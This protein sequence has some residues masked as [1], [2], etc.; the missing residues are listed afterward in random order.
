MAASK[1]KK[2]P[3]DKKGKKNTKRK[4]RKSK[5]PPSK[6][7]GKRKGKP[8][9]RASNEESEKPKVVTP[10]R[11][12]RSEWRW[13][14]RQKGGKNKR[15]N[16]QDWY[17][18]LISQQEAE[19]YLKGSPEGTFLVRSLIDREEE[20]VMLSVICSVKE[21]EAPKY[22]H[23]K[24]S[25]KGAN[26]QLE[27]ETGTKTGPSHRSIIELLDYY[28]NQFVGMKLFTLK[29]P[30]KRPDWFLKSHKIM[31]CGDNS[32]LGS[33][34]FSKV[35]I[36][37]FRRRLVAIKIL[38]S[39]GNRFQLDREN[40]MKEAT[41]THKMEH[42][43]IT[44]TIGIS[45]D[46]LPPMLVMELMGPSLLSHLEKYGKYTTIGEKLHYCL[47]MAYGLNYMTEKGIVHR[48]I[49]ARNAM[50]SRY[51]IL[52]LA[53]FGLSDFA[54]NLTAVNT[55][56]ATLPMK[57]FPPESLTTPAV[58]NEKTDVWMF[59]VT[60]NEI[61]GNGKRPLPQFDSLPRGQNVGQIIAK[62]KDGDILHVF[63][64]FVPNEIQS[65]MKRLW[66]RN[67][68]ERPCFKEIVTSLELWIKVQYPAPPL[69]RQTVNMIPECTP[70][71]RAEYEILYNN[72]CDWLPA[73]RKVKVKKEKK[74]T[75]KHSV[76]GSKKNARGTLKAMKKKLRQKRKRE[77]MRIKLRWW[78]ERR[79]NEKQRIKT[80]IDYERTCQKKRPKLTI[81]YKKTRDGHVKLVDLYEK[82]MIV[83]WRKRRPNRQTRFRLRRH[84]LINKKSKHPASR[85]RKSMIGRKKKEERK[86]VEVPKMPK[87][88]KLVVKIGQKKV[89]GGKYKM[90][91]TLKRGA[92]ANR[93]QMDPKAE[94]RMRKIRKKKRHLMRKLIARKL[95]KKR[96]ALRRQRR[97]QTLRRRHRRHR[98]VLRKKA[99]GVD[100]RERMRN[101][102]KRRRE[103]ARMKNRLKRDRRIGKV[104]RDW[105]KLRHILSE[106]QLS[107]A[108][109]KHL[110]R[111]EKQLKKNPN[112]AG[113]PKIR[114]PQSG[115]KK[116][117]VR[118]EL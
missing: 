58:F 8:T 96:R 74:K 30:L 91:P 24:I 43:H 46:T 3:E 97:R 22:D 118:S 104:L 84:R 47:Q 62:Y 103:K 56:R 48:D 49:S 72:N 52:K 2:R 63:P 27:L 36:G 117:K 100:L 7:N 61:F 114:T 10:K 60:C 40:L 80:L 102:K 55:A 92:S 23:L 86:R 37:A 19:A 89:A 99:L 53:D 59:G 18:G 45:I 33:G 81:G 107:R 64:N 41:I 25:I 39:D 68:S 106:R 6:E 28:H 110:K 109:K 88:T 65:Q 57:W 13:K 83:R 93:G 70:L 54:V 20:V 95:R 29:F 15:Y 42:P 98:L 32:E 44:K 34:N 12:R 113:V 14:L 66:L 21:G 50:F 9:R 85:N 35:V 51:G 26:W 11:R 31:T 105:R 4:A 76:V 108:L 75:S 71:T 111:S 1:R 112:E 82:L 101:L 16:R 17:W 90:L 5:R 67:N 87:I 115:R 69:E 116:K 38:T 73:V 78:R 79:R 94:K 77:R